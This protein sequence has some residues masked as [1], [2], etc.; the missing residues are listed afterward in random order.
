MCCSSPSWT[1]HASSP[2]WA[3]DD[4]P[5]RD[6]VRSHA[7]AHAVVRRSLLAGPLAWSVALVRRREGQALER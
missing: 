6:D 3:V 7:S 1:T 2:R 4:V 5:L